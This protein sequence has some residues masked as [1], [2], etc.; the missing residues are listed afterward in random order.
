MSSDHSPFLFIVSG[1]SG[2]GKTTLLKGLLDR[3]GGL[4][5]S[6]SHTTRKPRNGDL[7]GVDY[8]FIDQTIFTQMVEND[9][10]IEHATVHG[11]S[12]GTAFTS[13]QHQLDK[14][15]DVVLDIDVQGMSKI[16]SSAKFDVVSLF[17]LPPS[18]NELE[19]RLRN[20]NTDTEK[21]I[22]QRLLNAECEVKKAHSYDY[23]VVNHDLDKSVAAIIN[24]VMVER[25]RSARSNILT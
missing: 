11:N 19:K 7:D 2:C 6:I 13:I 10:F 9:Q 18:M 25:L 24:I 4:G 14:G 21:V 20:R 12:Y 3:V 23:A 5:K 15:L 1:P 8:H 16:V 22:R 17:V